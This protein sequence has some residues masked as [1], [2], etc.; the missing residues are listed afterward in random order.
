MSTCSYPTTE[1][2]TVS[3]SEAEKMMSDS[4]LIV[5]LA[6]PALDKPDSMNV[7][8]WAKERGVPPPWIVRK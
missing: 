1:N 6:T 2:V 7:S 5:I 3:V 8:Y 4:S